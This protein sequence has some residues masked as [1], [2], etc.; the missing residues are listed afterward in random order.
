MS[1]PYQKQ[2]FCGDKNFGFC[3]NEAA[4]PEDDSFFFGDFNIFVNNTLY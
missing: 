4:R 1:I 3:W 2:G